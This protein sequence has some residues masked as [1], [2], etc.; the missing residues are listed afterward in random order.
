MLIIQKTK[1]KKM[2]LMHIIVVCIGFLI[3]LINNISL[4]VVNAIESTL[5]FGEENERRQSS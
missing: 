5:T 2:K 1:Q 4:H 3:V